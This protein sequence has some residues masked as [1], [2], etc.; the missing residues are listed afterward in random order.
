MFHLLQAARAFA[1]SDG[2][3]LT[4]DVACVLLMRPLHSAPGLATACVNAV[5]S[6]FTTFMLDEQRFEAVS[7]HVALQ[8]KTKPRCPCCLNALLLCRAVHGWTQSTQRTG[9]WHS[10]SSH[11]CDV[12]SF[13][14]W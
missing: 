14:L 12:L 1:L 10:H 4:V 7:E 9:L 3:A 8:L 13:H 5:L 6:S 2:D 11:L